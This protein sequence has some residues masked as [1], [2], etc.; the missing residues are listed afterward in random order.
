[1]DQ[2]MDVLGTVAAKTTNDVILS[3]IVVAVVLIVLAIPVIK[4][5]SKAS[6][7]RRQQELNREALILDVIKENT[8]VQ[9]GLKTLLEQNNKACDECK[10]EQYRRFDLISSTQTQHTEL[11]T[12]I[13]GKLNA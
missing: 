2:G 8:S 13:G 1:M 5:I 10:T 9:A 3:M 11:L 12:K 4:L 6:M 7:E